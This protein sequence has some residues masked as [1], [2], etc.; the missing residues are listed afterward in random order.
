MSETADTIVRP[1]TDA[2]LDDV[3]DLN[4]RSTPEVGE[5]DRDRLAS[6]VDRASL[7]LVARS[8]DGTLAGFVIVLPPGADYDSPNYRHFAS[9]YE[10]FRYVDRIAIDPATHRG[11]L[12][13]RFYDAVFE[14][15]REAGAPVV[16]AE[17]NIDPPNPVSLAFHGALGFVEV[18][19]QTNYGGTTTVQFLA[20]PL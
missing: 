9:A 4:Q 16:L 8:A 12:G 1:L 6:I 17:G 19:Q 2:D 14:H 15:A 11:G 10:D 3:L 13:R 5:V 18:G 20:R 7:S